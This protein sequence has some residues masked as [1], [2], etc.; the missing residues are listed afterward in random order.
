MEN[1][2]KHIVELYISDVL[3]TLN[4]YVWNRDWEFSEKQWAEV[5]EE[6]YDAIQDDKPEIPFTYIKEYVEKIYPFNI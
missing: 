1:I 5:I 3:E 2:N 4:F 6:I